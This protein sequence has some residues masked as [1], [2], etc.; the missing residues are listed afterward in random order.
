MLAIYYW[1]ERQRPKE[2]KR[3]AQGHSAVSIGSSIWILFSNSRIR[4]FFIHFWL[5]KGGLVLSV[6]TLL[7]FLFGNIFTSWLLSNY[8]ASTPASFSS[9]SPPSHQNLGLWPRILGS[10]RWAFCLILPRITP[11]HHFPAISKPQVCLTSL[12]APF[13]VVYFSIMM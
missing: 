1:W 4:A 11:P 13:Y 6:P 12:L 7:N 2:I 10:D 9:S 5:I 3:L 8:A